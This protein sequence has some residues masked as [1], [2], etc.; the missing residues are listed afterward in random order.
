MLITQKPEIA[1]E[2]YASRCLRSDKIDYLK[3]KFPRANFKSTSEWA[4]AIVDEIT[5]IMLPGDAIEVQH[6]RDL[7]ELSLSAA[8]L[9]DE[10]FKQELVLDE[11]LDA[12]I[13]R[14]V[15]RRADQ[16]R[17]A[18]AQLVNYCV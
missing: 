15:K 10:L 1:F 3:R 12:M 16:S 4:Q 7:V 8:T 17:E 6:G 18:D 5:L 9:S 14:A 2:E 11:R 13:D